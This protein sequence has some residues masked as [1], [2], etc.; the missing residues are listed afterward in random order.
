MNK[1]DL[2]TKIEEIKELVTTPD[3]DTIDKGVALARELNEPAVFEAML[4]DCRY[5]MDNRVQVGKNAWGPITG[6]KPLIKNQILYVNTAQEF[7]ADYAFLN[8]IGYAPDDIEIDKSIQKKNITE[9]FLSDINYSQF[10]MGILELKELKFLDIYIKRGNS[11]TLPIPNEIDKLSKLERLSWDCNIIE[12]PNSIKK[13][14]NLKDLDLSDNNFETLPD[15]VCQMDNLES[16][17]LC[18]NKLKSLPENI[19][20]MVNLK[21]NGGLSSNNNPFMTELLTNE[22]ANAVD[23]LPGFI[24]QKM[25]F[26]FIMGQTLYNWMDEHYGDNDGFYFIDV[27]EEPIDDYDG[28]AVVYGP[29]AATSQ[30]ADTP[31]YILRAISMFFREKENL[32]KTLLDNPNCPLGVLYDVIKGD[33]DELKEAAAKS[34]A[35]K[36]LKPAGF[37]RYADPDTGEVIAK[38][39]DGKLAAV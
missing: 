23:R 30:N 26:E 19:S 31:N 16:L 36:K 12:I 25:D 21:D 37:G 28:D 34:P 14:N 18:N 27:P 15:F 35:V 11:Y 3:Y 1:L 10:P 8:L 5:D 32:G 20:G 38:M 2:D 9:L 39:Q 22:G 33:N 4:K 13:L 29:L 6:I 7:F 17:G 24:G